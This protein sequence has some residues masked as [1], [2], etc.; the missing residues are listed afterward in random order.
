MPGLVGFTL[1]DALPNNA[2]ST[3]MA[4]RELTLHRDFYNVDDCFIDESIAGTRSHTQTL[5][6]EAQPY[7]QDNIYVWLDGE[8]YERESLA[9]HADYPVKTDPEILL[10]LYQK[11]KNFEFLRQI[12]GIFA[13]VLYDASLQ[14][15][16]LIADRRGLRYLYWTQHQ[17]SLVWCSELKSLLALPN[18]QVKIDRAAVEDF[19]GLRYKIGDRS[20]FE[21]VELLP[22]ATILTW[23]IATQTLEK[24][25]YWWWT[26]IEPLQ[27]PYA[28]DEL[29]EEIGQR[30]IAAVEKRSKPLERVGL[31]LSG[32]LD[33]R[34][35]LAA[36]PDAGQ[37]IHAVGLGQP[38]CDDLVLAQQVAKIK[39]A[40]FHSLE[41]N[42]ENWL[43][44]LTNYL[45]ETD[46][47]CSII[48]MQIVPALQAIK[49]NHW[50][51]F[52]LNGV[53][54]D[55]NLGGGQ[56]FESSQL[57]YFVKMRLGLRNF[58]YSQD[59]EDAVLRRFQAYF[60]SI[61][62]S[63]YIL[64]VDN[65]VRSFALK[66]GKLSLID[67]IETRF[68]FL[69]NAL[70][71]LLYS[72]PNQ[73]LTKNYLYEKMLLKTFPDYYKTIPW[74]S[75]GVP[76][77]SPT[78]K[79][80]IQQTTIKAQKKVARGLNKVGFNINVSQ[81]GKPR[82]ASDF[83]DYAAWLRQNPG[84]D[85]YESVLFNSEVLYPEYVPQEQV[86]AVWLDHLNGNRSN[87]DKLS[88]MVTLELWLQ[89]IFNGKYR[90]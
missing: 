62:S 45:W 15:V 81:I 76:I 33:S 16:Y 30:F 72:L 59:H 43:D 24:R 3:L 22:A 80:R 67:G 38:N 12:D 1:S 9:K 41:M 10:A 32:G 82:L 83:T 27:P 46:A 7:C 47:Y 17:N 73:L 40:I 37:T 56:L 13:A 39:G 20:W 66:D 31:S 5:Q 11:D 25:R 36:M 74:Q 49:Q 50:Y 58:A 85:F 2:Q 52:K 6:P 79:R 86:K 23:D 51:D 70:E 63:S 21:G 26:E 65:R 28:E 29:A 14:K 89:Q 48:H 61:Q 68:P 90:P 60:H 77:G 54:G 8:F 4:M 35:I 34:A 57:D 18:Y 84:R 75:T 64:V 19:L 87:A 88:L 44:S 42:A 69:D 78:L 55:A 53:P 71:E